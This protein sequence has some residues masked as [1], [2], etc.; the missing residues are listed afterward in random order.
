MK[1]SEV[2][3]QIQQ[4]ID[5]YRDLPI[6]LCTEKA[7]EQKEV[8]EICFGRYGKHSDKPNRDCIT[9]YSWIQ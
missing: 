8:K 5:K 6:E 4:L 2:I 7:F 1:A 9:L 3:K